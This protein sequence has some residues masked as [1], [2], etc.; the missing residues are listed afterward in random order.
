MRAFQLGNLSN[1]EK[2][3]PE[4]GLNVAKEI[5]ST[6]QFGVTT[7]YYYKRN[8]RF[9]LNRNYANGKVDMQRFMDQL[10]FK[11]KFNYANLSWQCI[12]I[13]NRIISGEVNKW[14]QLNERVVVR[15]I[16]SLSVEQKD[17]EYAQLE[18][19]IAQRRKLEQLQQ[20]SGVQLIPQSQI[21][22][23]DEQ[24][25]LWQKHVQKLPEE[26]LNEI[27]INEAFTSNG[28]YSDIKDQILW[29]SASTGFIG[30]YTWM[31]D[32]GV[33]KVEKV[34][35]EGAIYSY[36]RYNDFRDTEWRGQLR[37]MKVSEIRVKYGVQY[38]GK[39]SEEELW[40]IA[41]TAKNYQFYNTLQWSN[42]WSN[43]YI[44]PYD[45][46]NVDVVE[47]ELRSPDSEGYVVTETRKTKSK[48]IKKS[49]RPEKLKDNEEYLEDKKW[50][51]YRGVYV[52]ITQTLLEWGIKKN[53]I[54]P[55]DPKELGD[56]E[57]SYSFYM[58]QN[59]D[60]Y[61]VA[62]PEKIQEAVDMMIL[63]R[64]KMEQVLATMRPPGV[65]VNHR[66]IQN[67]D[68]GLGDTNKEVD[69]MKLYNQ[70]GN[71]YYVD[72]DAEGRPIG[73]PFKD[74]PNA[75]FGP[76]MQALIQLYQ[77][78]YQVLK[79]ELGEDPNLSQQALQPRVTSG[80]VEQSQR[81]A[82][83]AT[84]HM[85][86]AYISLMKDTSRKVACLVKNS[87]M[88]GATVYRDLMNKEQIQDRIFSAD[89]ELM[90]TQMELS[91]LEQFLQT[92]LA[93]NPLLSQYL[94]PFQ[95]MRIAKDNL[96]LAEM[97]IRSAQENMFVMEME[98][99]RQN[100]QE[101]AEIQAQAGERVEAAKQKTE[102]LKGQTEIL[103]ATTTGD[104][105]SK[106]VVLGG[107]MNMYIEGMKTGAEMPAEMKALAK[108]VLQ[109][110]AIPAMS[111]N[112]EMINEMRQQV[113]GAMQ[114]PAM[115]A[116]EPEMANEQPQQQMQQP[117]PEMAA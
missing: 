19:V 96:K 84:Y 10:D 48:I 12:K 45:S 89:I 116:G 79:D 13:V 62:I 17:D 111:E 8:A 11:G 112:E 40:K 117:Q 57:F 14:M 39:L 44:R 34:Q 72:I 4:W 50:N 109:N 110:V 5:D 80:N 81:S 93:A 66:A 37:S 36:S 78:H 1:K 98:K 58:Y 35:P 43:S 24:L 73:D 75:G 82:D 91:K 21:P 86:S 105:E 95:V 29:D 115:E 101:Q 30:T 33:V 3:T 76:Q 7:N 41:M 26:V 90:P 94:D 60:M 107:I 100:S 20:E 71:F 104:S 92:S 59:Y 97:Y 38:G 67:I 70:T 22:A 52:R 108:I 2:S 18:F 61:N 6:I 51:I 56:A 25:N 63:T 106:N 55:Q 103:K 28:L 64:L 77:F 42:S 27:A 114:P 49:A 74:S 15:A 65:G 23:N 102:Q 88:F 9:T 85:Y 99:T 47:F 31:D 87:V 54:R 69:A 53:M 68:Y 16:D 113:E 32:Q 46:W 83:F